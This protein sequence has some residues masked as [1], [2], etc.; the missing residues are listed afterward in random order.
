MSE[1]DVYKFLWRLRIASLVLLI[2]VLYFAFSEVEFNPWINFSIPLCYQSIEQINQPDIYQPKKMFN[3]LLPII[4]NLALWH[5]SY[6]AFTLVRIVIIVETCKAF[7][8]AFLSGVQLIFG[9]VGVVQY[10]FVLVPILMIG[11]FILLIYANKVIN[12]NPEFREVFCKQSEIKDRI[13]KITISIVMVLIVYFLMAILFFLE[14]GYQ[15]K[16]FSSTQNIERYYLEGHP[17]EDFLGYRSAL[18]FSSNGKFFANVFYEGKHEGSVGI[19]DALTGAQVKIIDAE[20]VK[21]GIVSPGEE[22]ILLVK[23]QGENKEK[24]RSV[25]FEEWNMATGK[26]ERDFYGTEELFSFGINKF[27]INRIAFSDDHQYVSTEGRGIAVW[28]YKNGKLIDFYNDYANEKR[29][30]WLSDKTY[31]VMKIPD[32][33]G[34]N[35]EKEI[36]IGE[37]NDNKIEKKAK[38]RM[39][40]DFRRKADGLYRVNIGMKRGVG[41]DVVAVI[42]SGRPINGVLRQKGYLDIWNVKDEEKVFSLESNYQIID[43]AFYANGERILILEEMY[44]NKRRITVWNMIEKKKEKCFYIFDAGDVVDIRLFEE[45]KKLIELKNPMTVIH[46]R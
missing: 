41:K 15:E 45:E 2:F 9:I 44:K 18:S 23:G 29:L 32:Y 39:T 36:Y 38:E 14:A 27:Y 28:N 10:I 31:I 12:K 40:E 16:K 13:R 5:R 37:I 20:N 43:I 17:Q 35:R 22:S 6:G 24:V 25:A 30:I 7:I 19:F 42:V 26:K 33:D 1:N 3:I 11:Y 21:Y 4:F 8:V 46:I 34:T